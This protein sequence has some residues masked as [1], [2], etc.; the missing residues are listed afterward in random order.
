MTNV[1]YHHPLAS[2][3]IFLI[4]NI[5]L[6]LWQFRRATRREASTSR[7]VPNESLLWLPGTGNA[8]M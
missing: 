8:R 1:I 4:V 2:F 6:L 7:S 3:L 5:G